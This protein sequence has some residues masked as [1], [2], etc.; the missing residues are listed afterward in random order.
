MWGDFRKRAG[1]DTGRGQFLM[2]A[3]LIL[4]LLVMGW[5]EFVGAEFPRILQR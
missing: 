3:V 1:A 5:F 2:A 4:V